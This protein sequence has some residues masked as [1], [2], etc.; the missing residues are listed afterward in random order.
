MSA[1]A[2]STWPGR[3][4]RVA[5]AGFHIESVSFLPQ[6]ATLADFEAVAVRGPTIV[7]SLRGTQTVMGGFI[8][9]CEREGVEMLPVVQTALG[10]IGPATDEA[11]DFYR[12]EIADAV[13]AQADALDGVLLFLHGAAWAPSH[14]DP[15]ADFIDAVRAALGPHKPLVVALDYHGNIDARTLQGATA[16]FA[17]RL[18]PHTDAG[19]TGERA[20]DCMVRTLRG[21]IAPV[22]AIAKPRVLVPSIFSAT[23]LHPLADIVAE[24]R[25]IEAAAGG[26]TDISVMAGFSYGDAHNTGFS[27][28]CVTDADRPRAQAACDRLSGRIHDCRHALYA[29]LKLYDTAGALDHAVARIAAREGTGP[30]KPFV[31]LEHA[32]RMND[33]TYLLRA[34]LERRLRRVAVPFLWDADAARQAA[35]AGAGA[36]VSLRLG[37]HSSDKAGGTLAVDARVVWAGPKSYRVSGAYM[38]G[39]PVDLGLSALLDIDGVSVSVVS[40]FAF[41]VDG[42]CFSVFGLD[43]ADFDIVVLRSKTHFRAFYE[44]AAEEIL[45]VDTP[46]YGIADVMRQPYRRL[47]RSRHFPFNESA[48][49]DAHRTPETP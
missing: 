18:S 23:A 43:I 9:V 15:E 3:R 47:D 37:G 35:A 49:P 5:V 21:E 4:P 1:P 14:A 31:L 29:P 16:A 25:A 11:V 44:S 20:A 40:S 48:H 12:R 45:I 19:R 34:V 8:A 33:S 24:S 46:D 32:D 6:A 13:A 22:W 38:R 2:S 10:A 7:D 42:D 26:Y 39:M 28:L 27:V 36:L 30:G 17:Y 41:A